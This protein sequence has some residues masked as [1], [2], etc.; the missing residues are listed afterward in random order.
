MDRRQEFCLRTEEFIKRVVDFPLM[1]SLT[2]E[3]YGRFIE[4]MV[5]LLSRETHPKHVYNLNKDEV[6]RIFTDVLTD[7]TQPKRIS[8]EDKKAYSYAT[9]FRE[10]RLVFARFKKEAR[11]IARMIPLS[12][13][14]IGR[15]D[16]LQR[17][18]TLGDAS[19]ITESG[20]ERPWEPWAHTINLYG[21]GETIDER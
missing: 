15:L 16:S 4:K 18:V 13:N 9:P 20:E 12:V 5:I 10:Y 3:A 17:V 21:V 19:Y 1:R 2:D 11:E 14:T 8:L 7:I 6:R